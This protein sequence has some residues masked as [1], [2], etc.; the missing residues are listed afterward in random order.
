MHLPLLFFFASLSSKATTVVYQNFDSLVKKS[1]L[2]IAGKV[3]EVEYL[4]HSKYDSRIFTTLVISNASVLNGDGENHQSENFTIRYEG[5]VVDVYEEGKLVG[6]VKHGIEGMPSFSVNEEVILFIGPNGNS[7]IPFV[8]MNQGVFRVSK[9]GNMLD[10]NNEVIA[11]LEE[12][13]LLVNSSVGPITKH[14]RM[15]INGKEEDAGQPTLVSSDSPQKITKTSFLNEMR[16]QTPSFKQ[17]S[18]ADMVAAVQSTIRQNL[19]LKASG[20]ETQS[21][22]P[23]GKVSFYIDYSSAQTSDGEAMVPAKINKNKAAEEAEWQAS[24]TPIQGKYIEG[25]G[26]EPLQNPLTANALKAGEEK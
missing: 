5:G 17:F 4:P 24:H 18:R 12:G 8:G 13:D 11:G 14:T 7:G 26:H 9:D 15:L 20:L 1:D 21:D 2:V 19:R 3:V 23:K 6:Y 22:T 10:A 25:I 16:T